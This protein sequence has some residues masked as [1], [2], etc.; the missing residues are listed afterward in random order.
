MGDVEVILYFV[1]HGEFCNSEL[2]D[3]GIKQSEMTG[4]YLRDKNAT[5]L[6]TSSTIRAVQTAEHMNKH[7]KLEIEVFDELRGIN[8]GDCETL[9]WEY[10]E[11]HNPDFYCEFQKH[12]KDIA[13]PNGE[14]GASY[15]ERVSPFIFSVVES[16]CD[17]MIVVTHGG[18]IK[19]LLSGLLE[20]PQNKRF[21]LGSPLVNCSITTVIYDKS[22]NKYY[23]HGFNDFNHINQLVN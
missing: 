7:L 9:G 15:W 5:R 12:E 21:F 16:D 17:S 23:L 19:I 8:M 11:K 4:I 2:N 13:Y 22:I 20:M 18:A 10:V 1:R 6:L 3:T 14:N